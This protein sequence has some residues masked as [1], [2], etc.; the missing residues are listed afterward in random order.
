MFVDVPPGFNPK[1]F[2]SEIHHLGNKVVNI[3]L[4]MTFNMKLN[5]AGSAHRITTVGSLARATAVVL[6]QE[7][8]QRRLPAATVDYCRIP[9][10]TGGPLRL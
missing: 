7:C 4:N 9:P 8:A 10:A 6:C 1:C 5:A 3:P 2:F